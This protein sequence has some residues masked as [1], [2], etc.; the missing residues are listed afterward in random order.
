MVDDNHAELGSL[1]ALVARLRQPDG[2]P[3]DREQQLADLRA[4]LIEEAHEVATAIDAN[5][6][7]AI[8]EELGDLL[9]QIAFVIRLGEESGDTELGAVIDGIR[10]KMIARHP[11]VFG[12]ESADDADAVR[13]SWERRKA[14][15]SDRSL[16]AG[17]PSSLPALLFAFR[18]TQKAAGVGF[19]WDRSEAVLAKL[20]EE[21]GELE[22]EIAATQSLQE[23]G[24]PAGGQQRD[25]LEDELGDVLFTAANLGRHLGLD[26]EAALARA[27]TKFRRRFERVEA[28]LAEA[29]Q[30]LARVDQA[31]LEA[32]W[33]RVKAEEVCSPAAPAER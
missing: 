10:K 5:D 22:V 31:A 24:S 29:G 2:C 26:P 9:F 32:L 7:P 23:S 15:A 19:D 20:H 18:M 13:R 17:L 8:V 12:D 6:W 1:T 4:Y 3:W 33:Q 30:T 14:R 27:N 16:L 25:R 21:I 28:M 11:H